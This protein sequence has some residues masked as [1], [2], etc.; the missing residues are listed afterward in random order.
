[1]KIA[2]NWSVDPS[3]LNLRKDVAPGLG[4]FGVIK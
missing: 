4:L 1:M 3:T 2:D